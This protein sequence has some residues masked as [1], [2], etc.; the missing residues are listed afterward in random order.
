MAA[1]S[2]VRWQFSVVTAPAINDDRATN[3]FE[4]VTQALAKTTRH[5]WSS[6][7]RRPRSVNIDERKRRGNACRQFHDNRQPIS[8]RQHDPNLIRL[9]TQ[10]LIRSFWN[11]AEIRPDRTDD[12]D[13]AAVVMSDQRRGHIVEQRRTG[14]NR[15]DG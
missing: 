11:Q 14:G 12:Q 1:L 9:V 10:D 3:C 2:Q 6:E 7:T 15:I 13:A 4:T 5:S 8:A